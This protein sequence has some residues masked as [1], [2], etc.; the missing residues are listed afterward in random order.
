V[1]VVIVIVVVVEVGTAARAGHIDDDALGFVG[2]GLGFGGLGVSLLALH[3]A[4]A[5][6]DEL[7]DVG[8]GGS[9]ASGDAALG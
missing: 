1:V 4:E 8:H 5:V 7:G 6:E 9:L 3:D 2:C